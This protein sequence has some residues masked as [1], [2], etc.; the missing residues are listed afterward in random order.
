M[1]YKADSAADPPRRDYGVAATA[2]TRSFSCIVGGFF[3]ANEFSE[4]ALTRYAKLR[5]QLWLRH[6]TPQR[7]F[8]RR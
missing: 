1:P 2:A 4:N 8:G 6:P 7:T 5:I 3:E